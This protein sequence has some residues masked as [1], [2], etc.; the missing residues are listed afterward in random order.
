MIYDCTHL[1]SCYLFEI[2]AIFWREKSQNLLVLEPSF[3]EQR[4]KYLFFGNLFSTDSSNVTPPPMNN[5]GNEFCLTIC[6]T[7][8]LTSLLKN[9]IKYQK[10]YTLKQMHP[11]MKPKIFSYFFVCFG[12]QIQL[13][14]LMHCVYYWNVETF[15]TDSLGWK[16]FAISCVKNYRMT[17]LK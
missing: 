7:I 15:L 1:Y 16:W 17:H 14:T 4:S 5:H 9:S 3:Q 6:R 8:I 10:Y 11:W 2:I 12:C 13:V